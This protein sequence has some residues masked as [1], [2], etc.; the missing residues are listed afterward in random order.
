MFCIG[1]ECHGPPRAILPQGFEGIRSIE[2]DLSVEISSFSV[3]ALRVCLVGYE[4]S[5]VLPVL[6]NTE[7]RQRKKRKLKKIYLCQPQVESECCSVTFHHQQIG[8]WT[9]I[10][11]AM[12][13]A[14]VANTHLKQLNIWSVIVCSNSKFLL[15]YSRS[16]WPIACPIAKSV[17]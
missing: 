17:N 3:S 1:C 4:S 6:P 5:A 7:R 15:L 16:L 13:E 9:L 12:F 10:G 2:A 11:W 8:C 14:V